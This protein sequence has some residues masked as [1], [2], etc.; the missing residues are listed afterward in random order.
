MRRDK[1]PPMTTANGNASGSR[2]IG[3]LRI[4]KYT[5]E[6]THLFED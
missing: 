6:V 4:G 3:V 2:G 5:S 1:K